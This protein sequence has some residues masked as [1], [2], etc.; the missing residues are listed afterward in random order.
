MKKLLLFVLAVM[1]T[2]FFNEV[3]ARRVGNELHFA[4]TVRSQNK[5]AQFVKALELAPEVFVYDD[6]TREGDSVVVVKGMRFNESMKNTLSSDFTAD[7]PGLAKRLKRI[8]RLTRPL[9]LVCDLVVSYHMV[10]T[11]IAVSYTL[12]NLNMLGKAKVPQEYE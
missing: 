1:A 12:R 4:D 5:R 6:F 11:G 8:S 7:D 10:P 9:N 2:S 3:S